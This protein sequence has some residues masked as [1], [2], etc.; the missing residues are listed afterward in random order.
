MVWIAGVDEIPMSLSSM[1]E[2]GYASITVRKVGD[3]TE[4]LHNKR[5]GDLIGLRGP[6]G[7]YFTSAGERKILVV[8]GGTGIAALTPL[9]DELAPQGRAL[10]VIIGA[11]TKSEILF[12]NRIMKP[13]YKANV[14]VMIATD[15]GTCG[16]K[17]L[18]SEVAIKIIKKGS[19]DIIYTCG[20]ELMMKRIFEAAE[21]NEI[22]V[23]ASLERIM[24]CGV[25][26][27]GSCCIGPYRVCRDGP[28]FRSE[29]LAELKE[30]GKHKRDRSGAR[31]PI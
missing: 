27:C 11:N 24:K 15:D 14:K 18:A 26:I 3:A 10:T 20:P 5:V 23:Q 31:I 30:F 6:Y 7:N 28:V 13:S 25:G 29:T 12:L 22:P 21:E 4:A 9:I 2:S 8:G 16:E 1:M 17:G 19:F